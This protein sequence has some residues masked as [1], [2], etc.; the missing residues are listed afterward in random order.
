LIDDRNNYEKKWNI[1]GKSILGV[2][3]TRS[4]NNRSRVRVL[5]NFFVV[6][7]TYNGF[8]TKEN[9]SKKK[10]F[11]KNEIIKKLQI[12]FLFYRFCYCLF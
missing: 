9:L 10:I 4:E 3:I 12:Y 8:V 2:R 5:V 1:A 7:K 6:Y 11:S